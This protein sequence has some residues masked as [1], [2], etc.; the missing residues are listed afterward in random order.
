MLLSFRSAGTNYCCTKQPIF[1]MS[2]PISPPPHPVYTLRR[3]DG[4]CNESLRRRRSKAAAFQTRAR[5]NYTPPPR[6][7]TNIQSTRETFRGS[8]RKLSW[9]PGEKLWLPTRNFSWSERKFFWRSRSGC[10][11]RVFRVIAR[12]GYPLRGR[13]KSRGR[14]G[15]EEE[16]SQGGS[17]F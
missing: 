10:A 16:G 15:E 13:G 4:R 8:R 2:C 1:L 11:E 7:K 5:H 9:L 3:P 6:A 14:R 12:R 17:R